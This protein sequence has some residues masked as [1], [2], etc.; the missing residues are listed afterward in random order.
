MDGKLIRA[1]SH[2]GHSDLKAIVSFS[3]KAKDLKEHENSL[4]PEARKVTS[5]VLQVRPEDFS[6]TVSMLRTITDATKKRETAMKRYQRTL[7]EL[8]GKAKSEP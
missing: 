7:S 3:L 2:L 5:A 4:S 8:E 1:L 6:G